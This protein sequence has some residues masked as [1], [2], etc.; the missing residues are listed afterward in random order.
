MV[1]P[2][3]PRYEF[4]AFAQNFGLVVEKMRRLSPCH[5]IRESDEWYIMS[6]ANNEINTK[7]RDDNMDIKCFVQEKA[8]LE[9]WRP[10]TKAPFPVT[11]ELL[12]DTIFPAFG[13]EPPTFRRSTYALD[14][15]LKEIIWPHPHLIPVRVFKRRFAFTIDG[16]MAEHA[17]LLINGA[18]IQTVAVESEDT[19]VV[20]K[21]KTLLGLEE[22]ENVN[23]LL[24]IKRIIGLEPYMP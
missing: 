18:A 1:E 15:F 21:A 3:I 19:A 23:Y 13:V 4:R 12:D 10:L 5:L 9:Q 2:I 6:A 14:Q 8:G 22:Y 11:A 20:V 24:A 17:K 16:C 7:I